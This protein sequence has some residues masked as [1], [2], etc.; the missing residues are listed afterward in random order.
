ME[1]ENQD[2]QRINAKT[3]M[4]RCV[5]LYNIKILQ[6]TVSTSEGMFFLRQKDLK[7]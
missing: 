7:F 3:I 6:K 4:T 2:I 1:L 5:K